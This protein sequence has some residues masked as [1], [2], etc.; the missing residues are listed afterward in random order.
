MKGKIISNFE[1]KSDFFNSRFA[2]QRTPIN[3]SSVLPRLE[4][5]TNGLLSAMHVKED[6]IYIV[7]YLQA[8]GWDGY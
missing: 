2:S 4:Y 8:H 5:K 1:K 3:N 7:L 6:D